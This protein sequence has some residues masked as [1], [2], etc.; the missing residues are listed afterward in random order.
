VIQFLILRDGSG[1]RIID[2]KDLST[3]ILSEFGQRP[4]F[5]SFERLNRTTLTWPVNWGSTAV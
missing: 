2:G 4:Y 1:S 3:D 5:I